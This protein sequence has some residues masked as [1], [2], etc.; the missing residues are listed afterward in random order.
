MFEIVHVA[1]TGGTFAATIERLSDGFFFNPTTMAFESAPTF[2]NKR[3]AL[4]EGSNENTGSYRAS[5][6]DVGSPRE[7]LVRIHDDND[8][9]D[10]TVA[11][12]KT[13]ILGDN[14]SPSGDLQD[15]GAVAFTFT[16]LVGVVPLS[17]VDVWVT[18]DA[19]GQNVVANGRTDGAGEVVFFLD[20]GVTYYIFQQKAGFN[21][22]PNPVQVTV[23]T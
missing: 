14:E 1:A 13:F 15:A 18:T 2:A 3:I 19:A 22:D 10:I 16:S 5:Q 4:A 20:D 9:N 23:S 8:V 7:V 12:F 17:D 11:A 21:F 6:G